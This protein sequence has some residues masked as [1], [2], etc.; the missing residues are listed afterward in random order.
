MYN[1]LSISI[2]TR[3]SEGSDFDIESVPPF[4]DLQDYPLYTINPEKDI[5]FAE[6]GKGRSGIVYGIMN[7]GNVYARKEFIHESEFIN[8][9]NALKQL[10][11]ENVIKLVDYQEFNGKFFVYLPYYKN[12]TLKS[13]IKKCS[14]SKNL[15]DGRILIRFMISLTKGLKYL[16]NNNIYHDD[17]Y[18][19]NILVADDY[20]LVISDFGNSI[21]TG[22]EQHYRA[23]KIDM[24]CLLYKCFNLINFDLDDDVKNDISNLIQNFFKNGDFSFDEVLNDLYN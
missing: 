22:N 14:E 12:G 21:K 13:F 10:D 4:P 20:Q 8:E 18:Y 16:Q 3:N 19:E 17:L 7:G 15:V 6:L 24:S 23:D 2:F 1:L 9:I 5:R 11:H